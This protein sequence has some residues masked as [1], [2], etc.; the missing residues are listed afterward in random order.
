MSSVTDEPDAAPAVPL[1]RYQTSTW[2]N[3][4]VWTTELQ[5][6]YILRAYDSV[7]LQVFDMAVL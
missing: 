4:S 3:E 2:P 6:L 7:I 1:V 5:F